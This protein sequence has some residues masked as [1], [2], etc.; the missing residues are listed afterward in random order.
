M[1]GAPGNGSWGDDDGRAGKHGDSRAGSDGDGL[2]VI[3]IPEHLLER[4]RAARARLTGEAAPEPAAEPEGAADTEAPEEGAATPEPAA[5]PVAAEP[6]AAEPVAAEPMPG[7]EA[8]EPEA[9]PEPEPDRVPALASTAASLP[10]PAPPPPGTALEVGVRGLAARS[11]VAVEPAR[12]RALVVPSEGDV[13]VESAGLSEYSGTR[14][15]RWLVALYTL[16]PLFA[17]VYILQYATGPKC[18]QAG[19]LQVSDKDGG[20]LTCEGD[21]LGVK[22]KPNP[23]VGAAIFGANC[24]SCHLASGAG[25][26]QGGTGRPLYA[27]GTLFEDFPDL[28]SHVQFVKG[29]TAV[30][31]VYGAKHRQAGPVTMPAFE[32]KLSPFDL[33][34]AVTYERWV[35]HGGV[36]SETPTEVLPEEFYEPDELAALPAAPSATSTAT[37][38][39]SDTATASGG[40]Q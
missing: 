14:P 38:A 10:P 40:G 15:P 2:T 39:P 21:K 27:Q 33:A 18:G 1:R 25:S 26:D 6:V 17:L 31:P 28:R 3:E 8:P 35:L 12:A 19:A 22:P 16:L 4:S 32:G 36:D 11:G 34:S 24:A 20:L 5:E 23:R 29:G 9:A 37:A 7:T 30:N 13:V